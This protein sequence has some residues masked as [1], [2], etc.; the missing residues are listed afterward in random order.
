M[1]L[2]KIKKKLKELENWR[3]RN[4]NSAF[5]IFLTTFNP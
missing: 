5:Y 3:L 1:F 4:I 2:V